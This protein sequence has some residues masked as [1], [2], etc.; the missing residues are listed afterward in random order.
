MAIYDSDNTLNI[1]KTD[2]NIVWNSTQS[3]IFQVKLKA[4]Q[5]IDSFGGC[6][7]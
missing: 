4:T 6:N 3:Q 7:G 2:N 1:G 5:K